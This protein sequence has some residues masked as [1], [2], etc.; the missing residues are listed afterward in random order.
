M[1]RKAR[2]LRHKYRYRHHDHARRVGIAALSLEE[3]QSAQKD[4]L[5]RGS[6]SS[7]QKGAMHYFPIAL[8]T[9]SFQHLRHLHLKC[10]SYPLQCFYSDFP[11]SVLKFR[12]VS[13]AQFGMR[14]EVNLPPSTLAAQFTDLS[15]EL[16]A[17]LCCHCISIGLLSKQ[18]FRHT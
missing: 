6:I 12:D 16:D 2:R 14:R 10:L 13:F 3:R 9:Y 5:F 7:D 8:F 17:N 1:I 18:E 11:L 15:S 4:G